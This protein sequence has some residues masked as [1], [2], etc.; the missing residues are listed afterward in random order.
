MGTPQDPIYRGDVFK[1]TFDGGYK[2]TDTR[3]KQMAETVEM[4]E[5]EEMA[6]GRNSE[7]GRN[8]IYWHGKYFATIIFCDT[9]FYG[10]SS[11]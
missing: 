10:K 11:S 1:V 6:E 8:N 2:V 4:A 3:E 5:T 7:N 9:N